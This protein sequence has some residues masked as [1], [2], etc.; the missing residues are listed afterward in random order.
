[1]I[2]RTRMNMF[3]K[4]EIDEVESK[5]VFEWFKKQEKEAKQ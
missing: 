4:K 2:N 1:M 3:K 5:A